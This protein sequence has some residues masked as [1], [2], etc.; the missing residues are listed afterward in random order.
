[1]R[2]WAIRWMLLG[3]IALLGNGAAPSTARGAP[4]Q[5]EAHVPT[6]GIREAREMQLA[7]D[8][9]AANNQPLEAYLYYW[10]VATF[11]PGTPHGRYAACRFK[12]MTAVLAKPAKSPGE[13][14]PCRW[15]KELWDLLVW[16]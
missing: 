9:S 16:P 6:D 1:M 13:E 8:L 14:T 11:F 5:K 15:G 10:R 2:S 3:G 7:A 4:P 12:K